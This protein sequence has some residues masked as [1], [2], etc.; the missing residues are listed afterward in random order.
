MCR[1]CAAK[2]ADLVVALSHGGLDASPYSPRWKTAVCIATTGI[3]ALMLGTPPDFRKR[4]K[5]ARRY[6]CFAGG[7]AEHPGG[8][9]Q[10]LG[11]RHSGSDGAKL[12][13]APGHHQ[14]VL[15]YQGGKWVAKDQTNVEA[16]GFKYADSKTNIDADP[17]IAPLVATEHRGHAVLRQQPLGTTTDFEMSAYFSLVGDVSAIRSSTRRR[18][19]M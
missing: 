12:G 16:R 13:P 8:Y 1:R 11:Q 3:D 10:R 7:L 14:M 19:T 17:S 6:R 18:S 5:P 9:Q 4:V 15:K 2:G